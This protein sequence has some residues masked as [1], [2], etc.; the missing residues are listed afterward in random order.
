MWALVLSK[1][2]KCV[3]TNLIGGLF[4]LPHTTDE[5]S[6]SHKHTTV[7]GMEPYIHRILLDAKT[8]KIWEKIVKE[9]RKIISF[10][11][12]DVLHDNHTIQFDFYIEMN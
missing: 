5:D 7:Q 12:R 10:W 8:N 3:V 4:Q 11:I 1:K 9:N 2:V 6:D